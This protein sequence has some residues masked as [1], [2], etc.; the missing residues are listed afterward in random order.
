MDALKKYGPDY[1][2][3]RDRAFRDFFRNYNSGK[4]KWPE[5]VAEF[6]ELM[7]ELTDSEKERMKNRYID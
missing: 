6:D 7:E 1:E 3:F 5:F 2:K 4:K